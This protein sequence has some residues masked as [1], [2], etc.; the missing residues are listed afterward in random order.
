MS[1]VIYV[2]P[3]CPYCRKAILILNRTKVL[4]T[5]VDLTKEPGRKPEM[6]K[7]ANGASTVP[8]I[9]VNGAHIGDCQKLVGLEKS[10]QLR[11]ILGLLP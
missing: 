6:I 10:G 4:Y 9:F 8:Q 7:K 11:K 3:T 5:T 2:K 1:V